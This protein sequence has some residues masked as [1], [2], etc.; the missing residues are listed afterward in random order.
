VHGIHTLQRAKW[1]VVRVCSVGRLGA[2]CTARLLS[3]VFAVL[4]TILL[5]CSIRSVEVDNNLRKGEGPKN[6]YRVIV[7]HSPPPPPP[8]P[9]LLNTQILG[10]IL[11]FTQYPRVARLPAPCAYFQLLCIFPP[12]PISLPFAPAPVTFPHHLPTSSLVEILPIQP[13]IWSMPSSGRRKR[14]PAKPE[15]VAMGV[16]LPRGAWGDSAR[17]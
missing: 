1:D 16:K 8:P 5:K 9:S 7:P 3:L 6:S 2:G 12:N 10:S 17:A 4:R 15:M 13:Y 11:S 14:T